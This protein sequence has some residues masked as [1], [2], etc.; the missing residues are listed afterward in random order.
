ME[1][2]RLHQN[3][4]LGDRNA[5]RNKI[6]PKKSNMGLVESSADKEVIGVK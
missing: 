3:K 2:L 6:N 4:M 5:K 1:T